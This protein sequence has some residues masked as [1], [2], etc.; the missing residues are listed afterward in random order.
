MVC[1]TRTLWC[2]QQYPKT[3]KTY[4]FSVTV[5]IAYFSSKWSL[6]HTVVSIQPL[7]LTHIYN[8]IADAIR[9]YSRLATVGVLKS[10]QQCSTVD[11][12][13]NIAYGS[14]A[15]EKVLRKGRIGSDILQIWCWLFIGRLRD[16]RFIGR[17]NILLNNLP[18]SL[19]L[20]LLYSGSRIIRM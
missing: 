12:Q 3:M 18:I 5:C 19:R 15:A 6:L 20:D 1:N 9:F 8:P 17:V 13:E 2:S 11:W 14:I 10:K 16:L 4:K 7:T